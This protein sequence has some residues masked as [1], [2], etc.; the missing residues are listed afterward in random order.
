MDHSDKIELSKSD[1]G[2]GHNKS[3]LNPDPVTVHVTVQWALDRENP[4]KGVYQYAPTDGFE[5]I[6]GGIRP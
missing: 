6:F 5:D 4:K 3:I 1:S 2:A